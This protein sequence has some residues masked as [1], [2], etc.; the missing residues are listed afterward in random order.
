MVGDGLSSNKP[1]GRHRSLKLCIIINNYHT[2]VADCLDESSGL[3]VIGA[4]RAWHAANPTA[5]ITD[6]CSR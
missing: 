2:K 6:I 5:R 3:E 4:M 1:E